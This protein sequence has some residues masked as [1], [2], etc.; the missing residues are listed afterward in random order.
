MGVM[1]LV[2][3][4]QADMAGETNMSPRYMDTIR[5]VIT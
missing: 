1:V 3:L 2:I 5:Q 4:V